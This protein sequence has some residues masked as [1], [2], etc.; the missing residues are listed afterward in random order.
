MQGKGML[1]RRAV[2]E[3]CCSGND[4]DERDGDPRDSDPRDSDPKDEVGQLDDKADRH[5]I[6]DKGF[7]S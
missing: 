2:K 3:N 7:N 6:F 5:M 1:S 4:G